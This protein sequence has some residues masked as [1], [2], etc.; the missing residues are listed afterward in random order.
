MKIIFNDSFV[1]RL[2]KQVEYIALD[3][4]KRTRKFKTEILSRIRE[5]PGNPYHCRKSIY[6]NDHSIR[7]LIF[8]GYTIVFR[9]KGENIEVFGFVKSQ[10]DPTDQKE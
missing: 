5:V 1:A 4:L 9:L 2:E 7:D 3:S 10:K 6:F 8:K